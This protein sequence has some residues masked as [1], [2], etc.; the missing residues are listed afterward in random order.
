MFDVVLEVSV[1]SR[2][3]GLFPS[4]GYYLVVGG[5][6][7]GQGLPTRCWNSRGRRRGCS[8]WLKC[9]RLR[10]TLHHKYLFFLVSQGSNACL[11][12]LCEKDYYKT[13]RKNAHTSWPIFTNDLDLFCPNFTKI[14]NLWFPRIFHNIPNNLPQ[15]GSILYIHKFDTIIDTNY[16]VKVLYIHHFSLPR[17]C[18]L[19]ITYSHNI[20]RKQCTFPFLTFACCMRV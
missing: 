20:R 18:P 17:N 12:C 19:S 1:I 2:C 7:Q 9:S 8:T 10:P 3:W 6:S 15:F 16:I 11:K 14:T 5:Y 4:Q 13:R